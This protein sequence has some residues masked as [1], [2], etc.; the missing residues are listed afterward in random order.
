MQVFYSDCV[1][2]NETLKRKMNCFVK[3][4]FALHHQTPF[5]TLGIDDNSIGSGI[6]IGAIGDTDISLNVAF[7]MKRMKKNGQG[8]WKVADGTSEMQSET[9]ATAVS[10]LP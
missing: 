4:I 9:G 3:Y 6:S 5:Y 1:I 2:H 10:T 8:T 7:Q